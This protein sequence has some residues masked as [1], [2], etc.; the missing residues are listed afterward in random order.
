MKFLRLVAAVAQVAA[1]S[2]SREQ[3]LTSAATAGI[4]FT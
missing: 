1:V 3:P 2:A 4:S